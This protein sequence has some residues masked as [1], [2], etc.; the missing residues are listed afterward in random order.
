M[1]TYYIDSRVA[2]SG[3]GSFS[4]P[5]KTIAACKSAVGSSGH[6]IIFAEGSGPYTEEYYPTVAQDGWTVHFNN[7]LLKGDTDLNALVSAGTHKWVAS[8]ARSGEF[9]FVKNDG[10]S[11]WASLFTDS[12][13]V[14]SAVVDGLWCDFD[15]TPSGAGA[16]YIP[17]HSRNMWAWG[18]YDTL[19][20]QT[21]Y[22]YLVGG[23]N[24]TGT[25]AEILAAI[26]HY[27]VRILAGC[28]GHVLHDLNVSGA[29]FVNI[30]AAE[31]I[32]IHGARG[33]NSMDD[34]CAFA[35]GGAYHS[36]LVENFR[37][38]STG[39]RGFTVFRGAGGPT[40]L[41]TVRNGVIEDCHLG[42]LATG[43]NII[44]VTYQ[45]VIHKDMWAGCI[46]NDNA[47]CTLI[48]NHNSFHIN[49][50]SPHV[51]KKI[52]FTV[53]TPYWLTTDATDIPA[54]TNTQLSADNTPENCG[55]DP[56]ISD[57]QRLTPQSPCIGAGVDVGLTTD[58]DGNAVPG[59]VGFDIGPYSYMPGWSP[60]DSTMPALALSDTAPGKLRSVQTWKR[61]DVT[62]EEIE[63]VAK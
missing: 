51:N 12:T 27:N 38:K 14:K 54:S 35:G 45:N 13:F 58:A 50:S 21:F 59:A 10:S 53:A 55:V 4:S 8:T 16:A 22:V 24:P 57:E 29:N 30:Y 11:P 15:F 31:S 23:V 6:T 39:H 26:R 2:T 61:A 25:G 33:Y 41:A 9:Y 49:P 36:S 42:L 44:G 46:S 40:G 34:F 3:D 1:A 17:L 37:I 63:K 28:T 47:N 7:V 19:G 56:L 20:F 18:D 60:F 32:S 43:S 48:E 5:F 62:K 52:G